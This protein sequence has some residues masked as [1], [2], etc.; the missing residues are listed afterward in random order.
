VK[1]VFKVYNLQVSPIHLPSRRLSNRYLKT[2]T[3]FKGE[4]KNKKKMR[5]KYH[6]H[7]QSKSTPI[8]K[9]IIRWIKSLVTSS[10][11]LLLKVPYAREQDLD[12]A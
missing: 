8:F 6:M 3:W 10:R 2:S 4:H 1:V 7:L 11:E 5:K 9:G 12:V